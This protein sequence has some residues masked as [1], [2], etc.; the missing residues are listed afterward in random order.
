VPVGTFI[1]L[2]AENKAKPK[3]NNK[4]RD[5]HQEQAAEP[6][7]KSEVL[8]VLYQK[9]RCPALPSGVPDSGSKLP[10]DR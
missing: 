1:V 10:Y 8:R 3:Q 5:I 4:Q 2:S 9:Y 6:A 7:K